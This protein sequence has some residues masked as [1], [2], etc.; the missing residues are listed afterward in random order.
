[1]PLVEPLGLSLAGLLEQ[2]DFLFLRY[3]RART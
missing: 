3:D 2:D 1:M